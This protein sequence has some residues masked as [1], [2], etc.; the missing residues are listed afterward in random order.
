VSSDCIYCALVGARVALVRTFP[1]ER[2]CNVPRC[3]A[4]G[5]TDVTS[6]KTGGCKLVLCEYR[7]VERELP[8]SRLKSKPQR[9]RQELSR[10][11]EEASAEFW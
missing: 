4:N 7:I 3:D 9:N 6:N 5:L 11:E 2:L 8:S 1:R 10:N